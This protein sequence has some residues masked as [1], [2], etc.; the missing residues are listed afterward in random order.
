MIPILRYREPAAIRLGF[1]IRLNPAIGSLK[2]D[3]A[4]GKKIGRSA[5]RSK[6]AGT[7]TRC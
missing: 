4:I 3:Y 6:K 7:N 5:L 1:T 2:F